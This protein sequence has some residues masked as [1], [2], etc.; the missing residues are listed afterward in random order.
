M[1]PEGCKIAGTVGQP[2]RSRSPSWVAQA[3]NI[4]GAPQDGRERQP[5]GATTGAARF[6]WLRRG[7]RC[8]GQSLLPEAPGCS[9]QPARRW[10]APPGLSDSPQGASIAA[11]G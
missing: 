5:G 7:A 8:S 9:G 1:N 10:R 6:D 2:A 3:L 11:Q 4:A